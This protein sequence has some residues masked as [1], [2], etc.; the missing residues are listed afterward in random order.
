[1]SDTSNPRGPVSPETYIGVR[2]WPAFANQQGEP[3]HD[4]VTYSAPQT[5]LLHQYALDGTWQLNPTE[6][7]QTLVSDGGEIRMHFIGGELNLVLGLKDESKP[8]KA[9][10]FIDNKRVQEI[11]VTMHDLYQ[12][13]KGEYGEHEMRLVFKGAGVEAYAFTFGG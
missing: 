2:S 6:E 12:I 8:V 5:L 1:M 9:E 4:E 3:S 10:V 7:H 13:F 11:T